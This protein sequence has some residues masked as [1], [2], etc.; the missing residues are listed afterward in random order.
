MGMDFLENIIRMK[1]PEIFYKMNNPEI[2]RFFGK[3]FG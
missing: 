2:T 1:S 3:Y